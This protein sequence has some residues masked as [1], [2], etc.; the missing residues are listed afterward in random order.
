MKKD[1]F[2]LKEGDEGQEFYII[3][4]GDV[5]CL[6][7]TIVNQKP[8]FLS[9]RVLSK[10]EHFGELALINN[11]KRSLSIR[12]KSDTARLLKLDREAFT[13]ILGSIQQFLQKDYQREFDDK[14]DQV[15]HQKRTMSQ[16]FDASR[17][18]D[19]IEE[20]KQMTDLNQSSN[21]ELYNIQKSMDFKNVEENS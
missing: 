2:V 6:K 12:I 4:N 5:E 15:L 14:M 20:R 18:Q 9:V 10:G 16:M 1:D 3:E 11:E 19:A 13:R 8:K 21:T 7:L 17:F